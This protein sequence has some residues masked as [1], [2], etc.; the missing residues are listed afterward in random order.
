MASDNKN[1]KPN[2]KIDVKDKKL[3]YYLSMDARLSHSQISKRIGLSKNAV[4][5]RIERLKKLGVIHH[6]ASIVNLGSIKMTT[7]TLLLKFN[8]DIYDK[9]EI[10]EYFKE[11][12]FADWVVTLSGHWDIF[13]EMASKDIKHMHDL[14]EEIISKFGSNLNTYKLFLSNDT[15]RVE[16]LVEDFYQGLKLEPLPLLERT[17]HKHKLD[18]TDMKILQLLNEDSSLPYLEIARKL[19][20]TIDIVRYRIKNML[21][22][23]IIIKFFAEIDLKKLG[24]TEYL[25]FVKL[26]NASSER[27]NKI[28][29]SIQT[30]SN[31][32]YA[33]FD[34]NNYSIAFVCEFKNVEDVDTLS[35]HLQREFNDIIDT[36]E[37]LLVK[38]QI[39]FNLFPRGIMEEFM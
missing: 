12:P 16:H 31:I 19:N 2:L 15:L 4:K 13:V 29:K 34:V 28:R 5:Y 18:F 26:R 25:F 30:N 36:Q 17:P 21:D 6:F 23:F 39:L 3:I 9:P 11:H 20:L 27:F 33:F 1:I 14:V 22:K 37:Y 7:F 38:E 32:T 24:Y 8:E 10:I 35:R